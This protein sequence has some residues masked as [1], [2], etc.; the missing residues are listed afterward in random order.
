MDDLFDEPAE[1]ATA[2][3]T[4]TEEQAAQETGVEETQAAAETP[5]EKPVDLTDKV[6]GLEAAAAAERR[7]RQELE[8]QLAEKAQEEKPYLGEEY[9]QRFAE[10]RTEFQQQLLNQ[11]LDISEAFARE[12]YSDFD[13]KLTIFAAL[14]Q[15]NPALYDQ[16]AAQANPAEFVYR[17]ASNQQKLKE[18][19]DPTE[20]ENK[21]RADERAR[22]AAEYEKKMAEEGKK[23]AD[24][25]GSIATVSA[26]GGA[27]SA[28][29]SGPTSLDDLLK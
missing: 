5:T 26:A 20:Y 14:S 29:W 4:A 23:R 19:G 11:K 7:R 1:Q 24:L 8:R 3:E 21:I 15:E 6:K 2:T 22:V 18:M 16:M 12:K 13:D 9:E 17:T 25:P 27:T 28:T 10:T